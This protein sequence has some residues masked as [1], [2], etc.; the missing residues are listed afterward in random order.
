MMRI[1]LAINA[2]TP[3]DPTVA[4]ALLSL[5]GSPSGPKWPRWTEQV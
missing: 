5:L 3:I 4:A 2:S 1:Y